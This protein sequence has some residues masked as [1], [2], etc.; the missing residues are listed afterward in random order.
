MGEPTGGQR[1]L[2]DYIR[3]VAGRVAAE[4][5]EHPDDP[6]RRQCAAGLRELA[7]CVLRL[8][9]DDERLLELT[10][11]GYRVGVFAPFEEAAAA[12]AGF[13]RDDPRE[14]CGAF[15]ARLVGLMRDG[16]LRHA[17]AHG[18]LGDP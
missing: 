8:P 13:R 12:I 10:S 5:G 11:L 15:L 14:A 16:A 17:R 4:S 18:V 3:E 9:A 6:R 1:A 7:A 2:A